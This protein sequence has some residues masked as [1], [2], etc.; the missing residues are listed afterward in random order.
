MKDGISLCICLLVLLAL[1][2]PAGAVDAGAVLTTPEDHWVTFDPP[3]IEGAGKAVLMKGRAHPSSEVRISFHFGGP[4]L[5]GMT[6]LTS[7]PDGSFRALIS[8]PEDWEEGNYLVGISCSGCPQRTATTLKPAFSPYG[9]RASERPSAEPPPG[10]WWEDGCVAVP[11]PV[12]PGSELL[13]GFRRKRALEDVNERVFPCRIED[14]GVLALPGRPTR[15]MVWTRI[16]GPGTYAVLRTE[17]FPDT[18]AHWST[19]VAAYTR[20]LGAMSGYPDG[21]FRPDRPLT[22]AEFVATLVRL[23]K[24]SET[25][26]E[27]AFSDVDPKAWYAGAVGAAHSLGWI[28]GSGGSFEPDRPVTRAEACA[29][30]GRALGIPGSGTELRFSDAGAVP[31]WALDAVAYLVEKGV[32]SGYPDGSFKPS[33]TLT[34]AELA[35]L[36][37]RL[38]CAEA[39]IEP[40]AGGFRPWST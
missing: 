38:A 8:F 29:V 4:P 23:K 37:Y 30:L 5:V 3:D 21:T 15:D 2:L 16:P 22:R 10:C 27:G 12:D 9:K 14:G 13:M 35:A 34:R 31:G 20:A 19:E 40:P 26:A 36:L 33:G 39:G 1:V 17:T 11:G 6:S 32:V 28:Q 7:G 25:P 24:I 18:R